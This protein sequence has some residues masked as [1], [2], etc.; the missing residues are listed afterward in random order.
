MVPLF[1]TA[2]ISALRMVDRRCA[3]MIVV[4]FCVAR[5]LSRASWTTISDSLSSALVASSSRR[6]AGFETRTRAIAM[7]CFC[8]P[9]SWAPLSPTW[10]SYASGKDEMKSWALA[11]LAASSISSCVADGRPYRMFWAMVVANRVGSCPTYPIMLLKCLTLM[12]LM[13]VPSRVTDPSFG[14]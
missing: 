2:M 7:R 6:M 14:S 5:T 12:S 13:S 3:M 4:R 10:V 9:D 8:P 1:T 11:S